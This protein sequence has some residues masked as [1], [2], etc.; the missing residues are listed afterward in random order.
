MEISQ[1]ESI[2]GINRINMDPK[3]ISE[4]PMLPQIS[5]LSDSNRNSTQT[6]GQKK[7]LSDFEPAP[8]NII[9]DNQVKS[10]NFD[11]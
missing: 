2:S 6:A 4:S 3:M 7:Q 10:A 5:S 11:H 9:D 1:T 8:P